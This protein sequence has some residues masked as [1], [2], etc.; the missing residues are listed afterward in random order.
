[1]AVPQAKPVVRRDS[2]LRG[3]EHQHSMGRC[4][5]QIGPGRLD[6]DQLPQA[7]R[8]EVINGAHIADL[9]WIHS[10]LMVEA[11]PGEP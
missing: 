3:Q 6:L 1:M 5:V 9:G 11:H 2:G 8:A 10:E 7:V 4:V